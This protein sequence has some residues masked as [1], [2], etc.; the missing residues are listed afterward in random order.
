MAE[1]G[2]PEANNGTGTP[3]GRMSQSTIVRSS[4]GTFLARVATSVSVFLAVFYLATTGASVLGVYSLFIAVVEV[5]G[6]VTDAG[7]S[8]AA[9]KRIS[10]G[11]E[12]D[13][14][15]TAALL[16]RLGI[17]VAVAAV[18]VGFRGE[19][20][21]YIGHEFAVPFLL[22]CSLTYLVQSTL[23]E[24]LSGEKRVA[25]AGLLGFVS[26]GGRLV[27]WIPLLALDYGVFGILVGVWLGQV[28]AVVV[29]VAMLSLRL[30]RP[31]RRHFESLFRFAKYSWMGALQETSWIWTDTLILGVFV[32]PALV[33]VYEL[34]WQITGVLFFV[35]SAISSALFPSISELAARNDYD[36]VTDLLERSLVY[37]GI[38][39]IP[40]F[41]GGIIFAEPILAMFGDEYRVGATVVVVLLLARAFHSY[42]VVF[43]EAL[44]ALDRPDLMF[45]TN[46]VFLVLLISLN[47]V[48]I[49][50]FGWVGAAF[51]TTAAMVVRTA[52]SFYFIRS[53]LAFTVPTREIGFEVLAALFMGACL[54]VL[55]P[56]ATLGIPTTI[57]LVGTGAAIY[58]LTVLALIERV[59]VEASG[60]VSN[61]RTLL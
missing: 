59:R 2:E 46:L 47:V 22:L 31:A 37:V 25:R 61:V 45:R 11:V 29:G 41:V 58:A 34:S 5:V 52:L 28:L 1:W 30:R 48:G 14:F 26:N 39:S 17:F 60:L 50:L 43:G 32:A 10:E 27:A 55:T 12:R 56:D 20:T 57:L 18:L 21:A 16:T 54:W 38:M 23:Y 24:S 8:A 7:L 36:R 40:G 15:F 35:A 13:E 44:N 42:E 4:F 9:K 19:I 49:T 51:A 3:E 53:I 33:G 6:L